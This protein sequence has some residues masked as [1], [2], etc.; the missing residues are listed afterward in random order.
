VAIAFDAYLGGYAAKGSTSTANSSVSTNSAANETIIVIV[1]FDPSGASTPTISSVT[2]TPGTTYTA[3]APITKAPATPSSGSGVLNQVWIGKPS[4][5]LVTPTDTITVNFSAA[6]GACSVTILS[7]TGL[8]TTERV[9]EVLGRATNGTLA[10]T[11]GSATNGDLVIGCG[12]SETNTSAYTPDSD[13]TNGSWATPYCQA[14][15]G[16]SAATNVS[17]FAQYKIVTGTATQTWNFVNGSGNIGGTVFVLQP[18]VVLTSVT[19]SRAT[20]WDLQGRVTET[21]AT[22]WNTLK[23]ETKTLSATTW[24]TLFLVPIVARPTTWKTFKAETSPRATTWDTKKEITSLRATTWDVAQPP[25][26][27]QRSTTWDVIGLFQNDVITVAADYSSIG[28]QTTSHAASAS[29][30]AAVVLIHTLTATVSEVSDVTYGGVPMSYFGGQA[31]ATE[32]GCVTVF[33]LDNIPTGTQN[34]VMTTYGSNTKKLVV[35]TMIVGTPGNVIRG[36][37]VNGAL[38]SSTNPLV[39]GTSFNVNRQYLG[40]EA[41]TSGDDAFPATPRTSPPWSL[42]ESSD[43]GTSGRGFA[44]TDIVALSSTQNAGWFGS[45]AASYGLSAAWFYEIPPPPVH[46]VSTVASPYS[47]IGSQTVSHAGSASAR[48][49]VVMIEQNGVQWDEVRTVTYGGVPMHRIRFDT[50]ATE[51]GATY[52]YFLD[53]CPTGTQNAV[54]TTAGTTSKIMTISTVLTGIAGYH[55][56]Y[57][58]NGHTGVTWSGSN[59]GSVQ[60]NGLTPDTS[61]LLFEVMHFGDNAFD[62]NAPKAGWSAIYAQADALNGR[63]FAHMFHHSW[64]S[65][66]SGGWGIG[67]GSYVTSGISLLQVAGTTKVTSSRSTTWNTGAALY[68]DAA[69]VGSDYVSTGSQTVSHTASALAKGAVVMIVQN[70]SSTSEVSSVTYGG[71]SMVLVRTQGNTLTE[72]GRIY[73]YYLENPATGTQNVVMTTTGSSSKQMVISTIIPGTSGNTIKLVGITNGLGGTAINTTG[74]PG[75]SPLTV[76][77]ARHLIYYAIHSSSDS[78]PNTPMVDSVLISG[79]D[80]GLQGRG[81]AYKDIYATGQQVNIGWQLPSHAY[82]ILGAAFIEVPPPMSYDTSTIAAAYASIG[83]QTTSHVASA[84]ARA[85][86][87]MISQNGTTIDE[88]TGV[89]YGGIPMHRVRFDTDPI[90]PGAIYI[91]F[92]DG[93]PTGTQNVA[94]TTT[95][96][97]NRQ[98]VVST[99]IAQSGSQIRHLEPVQ[100]TYSTISNAPFLNISVSPGI[101]QLLFEVIHAG[102]DSFNTSTSNG[103]V[104]LSTTDLGSQA[105]GFQVLSLVPTSGSASSGWAVA[106]GASVMDSVFGSIVLY[107]AST[108][109]TAKVTS[110]RTTTWNVTL[111]S[112][113]R[114]THDLATVSATNTSVGTQNTTHNA[115]ASA[116][117]AIVII[118]QSG[119]SFSEISNVVYG[120]FSMTQLNGYSETTE[121]GGVYMYFLDNIPTGTQ[122]VSYDSSGTSLKRMVVATMIPGVAGNRIRG[123]GQ[124]GSTGGLGGSANPMANL[125]GLIVGKPYCGYFAIH[126]GHDTFPATPSY[127]W[128]LITSADDGLTG[129]GFSRYDFYAQATIEPA[130]WTMTVDDSAYITA[131]FVELPPVTSIVRTTWNVANPPATSARATTWNTKKT[132]TSSRDTTWNVL[133]T[134]PVTSTRSTTWKTLQ[135]VTDLVS[136]TWHVRQAVTDPIS[137]TWRILQAITETQPTTWHTLFRVAPT[138]RATTWNIFISGGISTR[139]TTWK[140]LQAV[141]SPRS[142]TWDVLANVP[143]TSTRSTTWNTRQ[144]VTETQPTTWH[145]FTTVAVSARST[146]WHTRKFITQSRDT[147]WQVS[148]IATG[149][150]ATTWRVFTS[151]TSPRS[152]TWVVIGRINVLRPTTWDTKKFITETQDTSWIVNKAETSARSTTWHVEVTTSATSV[153]ST[154]WNVR[155]IESSSRLTTWNVS[156][157]VPLVTRIVSWNVNTP[158]TSLRPTTWHT[159]LV[160]SNSRGTTWHVFTPVLV[161]RLTTWH[162]KQTIT[163]PVSTMWNT[164]VTISSSRPTTWDVQIQGQATSSRGTTWRVLVTAESSRPTTWHV[165]KTIS[166]TRPTT[167][168]TLFLAVSPRVTTWHVFTPVGPTLRSTTWNVRQLVTELQPTT[169]H[170]FTPVGPT[171]RSTTWRVLRLAVSPRSTTWDVFF[172]GGVT[173]LRVII[174]NTN[175]RITEPRPTTWNLSTTTTKFHS[176]TWDVK[177]TETSQRPTIWHV[178]QAIHS[179]RLTMWDTKKTILSTKLTTWTVYGAGSITSERS[180][181]WN[182]APSTG[183]NV[184]AIGV[185]GDRRWQAV[186]AIRAR[187]AVLDDQRWVGSTSRRKRTATLDLKRWE[188]QNENQ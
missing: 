40:Y 182:I 45:M 132:E 183:L 82:A 42:I 130:G 11:S 58:G 164:L 76:A 89:T 147:S 141:S 60:F 95:A 161:L 175:V 179:P 165:L 67:S 128:T 176:T 181:T 160:V 13:T 188:G 1:S 7:F 177:R 99:V 36:F 31:D 150:R 21:Q 47:S 143:V 167:W 118:A 134:V 50:D 73:L 108:T 4:R 8:S 79:T 111:T 12:G 186:T 88:I 3:L 14:T 178:K 124:F 115:S 75:A 131:A 117:A 23:T 136:T 17:S 57:V 91:Y 55:I 65:S 51:A 71:T 27:S 83:T 151:A 180:T 92:L 98:L 63:A 54:M 105:R 44:N 22:T 114:I 34:V 16:G 101:F 104:S 148:Q 159:R 152:T 120:G 80:L 103:W 144:V 142:T 121:P 170:V 119:S 81:F 62:V 33:F 113:P 70:G 109:P 5:A 53:G 90:E 145:V 123:V 174:W 97:T 158:T 93:I 94:M 37:V 68:H 168:N 59:S 18:G 172:A 30:R 157:T 153:R 187:T 156:F 102:H 135:A 137:T 15:T 25:I 61:H 49:V 9:A 163:D 29:A 126:S 129:Q 185:I 77:G 64:S 166:I 48:A 52:I 46:D 155:K 122:T 39:A 169:W 43:L 154:T 26:T 106:S 56:E 32:G 110:S 125:S 184:I 6:T 127:G 69:T 86:V 133:T 85:A 146:T 66:F 107:Q 2:D 171:T 87:V 149:S 162:V 116:Q 41:I 78:F 24:K 139:L 28:S 74:I 112:T 140:T 138:T 19:S 84:S 96:A 100:G 173:S 20:T 35:A 10:I 38:S 72:L